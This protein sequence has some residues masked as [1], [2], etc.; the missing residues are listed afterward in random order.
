MSVFSDP[1]ISQGVNAKNQLVLGSDDPRKLL[2]WMGSGHV[3]SRVL[4]LLAEHHAFDDVLGDK[5]EDIFGEVAGEVL[6]LLARCR[7]IQLETLS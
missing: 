5:V 6:V 4:R 7:L 1:G 3:L 2:R